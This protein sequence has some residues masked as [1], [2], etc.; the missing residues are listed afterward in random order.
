METRTMTYEEFCE[1][2]PIH[3]ATHTGRW[4]WERVYDSINLQRCVFATAQ[5]ARKNRKSA[6]EDKAACFPETIQVAA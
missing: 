3:L 4:G 2:Y 6:Y 1:A 5:I